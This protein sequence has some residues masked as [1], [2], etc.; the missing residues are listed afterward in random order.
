M[1]VYTV[2]HINLSD[3][4]EQGLR[5]LTK[6]KKRSQKAGPVQCFFQSRKVKENIAGSKTV[7]TETNSPPEDGI[8][9]SRKEDILTFKSST[10][11]KPKAE[12]LRALKCVVSKAATRSVL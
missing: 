2:I 12:V 4:R 11:A 9:A 5:S 7:E 1:Q 10:K 8:P 6:E 3:M